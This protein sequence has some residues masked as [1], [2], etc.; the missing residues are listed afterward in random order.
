VEKFLEHRKLQIALE[1][2]ERLQAADRETE[3]RHMIGNV[4]HDLK[5]PLSSITTAIEM[6]GDTLKQIEQ[7]V[8]QYNAT[9]DRTDEQNDKFQNFLQAFNFVKQSLHGAQNT[10][11]FMFM[12][13]NRCIDYTKAS[14]GI[15]LTPRPETVHWSEA[16][17]V[18][19]EC[20]RH[21]Q[22]KVEI[23]LQPILKEICSHIIT[24]KQWLQENVLC[25]LS[26]AVKYS[27]GGVVTV[28]AVLKSF[29]EVEKKLFCVKRKRESSIFLPNQNSPLRLHPVSIPNYGQIIPVDCFEVPV[30]ALASVLPESNG[31]IYVCFEVEDSGIGLSEEMMTGLFNPFKQAQRLAGGTGNDICISHSC[32]D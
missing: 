29:A 14:K 23:N 10:T 22:E 12:A 4:A 30:S 7:I 26:N 28:S 32:F 8:S 19:L 17:Q 20:M 24:D 11:N 9:G 25:L 18:P 1:D 21:I 31:E 13:I 5:T 3:L 2:I 16:L 15:K 6:I 27:N